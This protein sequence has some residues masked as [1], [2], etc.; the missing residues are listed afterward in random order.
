MFEL[1]NTSHGAEICVESRAVCILK[2]V[3]DLRKNLDRISGTVGRFPSVTS[4]GGITVKTAVCSDSEYSM[5]PHE[6]EAYTVSVTDEGVTIAGFDDLGTIYGIYAFSEQCL[7]IS[8]MYLFTDI[9]PKTVSE[10]SLDC[11]VFS[12]GTSDIRFRGWF[13]NDEDL[14]TDFKSGGGRRNIDYPYYGNVMHPD[15]LEI[16]LE[17]ALRCGCNLIIPSSFIDIDNPDEDKLIKKSVDRGLYVSQHHIEPMGVSYFTAENYMK[18]HGLDTEVSYIR[19][20]ELM[21]EIWRYYAGLWSKYSDKVIWQLGLRGKADRAVWQ[22]DPSVPD[23][24]AQRGAIIS[25]AIK[26]Q[27]DIICDTVGT[28]NFLSTTTLWMEGAE[29]YDE[30]CIE[31]PDSTIAVFSDIGANQMFG[32]D[33]YNTSRNASR[34]YGIYYHVAFWG[35][36]PHLAEGCDPEK[37]AY[38]YKAAKEYNS[39]Y[40]SITNVSNIRPLHYSALFNAKLMQNVNSFNAEGFKNDFYFNIYNDKAPLIADGMSRYYKCLAKAPYEWLKAYSDKSH[41]HCL[42]YENLP[43]AVTEGSDGWLM[44]VK[45]SELKADFLSELKRSA[46]DF[47]ELYKYW[48]SIDGE[49]PDDSRDYFNI[50]QKHQ[51]YFMLMMTK[52]RIA[53]IERDAST[54]PQDKTDKTKECIYCLKE[55]LR[56]SRVLE[57]GHWQNW[58]NGEKKMNIKG[59]LQKHFEEIKHYEGMKNER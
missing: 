35:H 25:E 52:R 1:F 50:Y 45:N 41:F 26:T 11:T 20:P 22:S 56:S 37:I 31:I 48:E 8:P 21:T 15:V 2:A 42:D 28:D 51:T 5:I 14:L 43:F 19:N 32:K 27:Y 39:L 34:K 18:K 12:K 17:T 24:N 38:S 23:S 36:G 49:I 9:F 59:R 16:V 6:P 58:L 53:I 33:F 54:A 47:C 10:L 29:L 7:G 44:N 40:Y 46:E 55:I 4:N 57:K 13:I 3:N 30:G